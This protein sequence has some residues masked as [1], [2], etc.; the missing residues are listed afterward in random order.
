MRACILLLVLLCPAPGAAQ[1]ESGDGSMGFLGC[2]VSDLKRRPFFTGFHFEQTGPALVSGPNRTVTFR[3]S[4]QQMKDLAELDLLVSSAGR[5]QQL[6][7]VLDRRL[8]EGKDTVKQVRELTRSFLLAAVPHDDHPAIV[9]LASEIEKAPAG[10]R[11]TQGYQVFQGRLKLFEVKMPHT[12]LILSNAPRGKGQALVIAL[13][14]S[15]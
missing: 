2:G 9:S 11:S 10:A 12:W 5:V 6:D 7:L 4:S 8:V 1:P 3:P 14:P 15:L 13:R